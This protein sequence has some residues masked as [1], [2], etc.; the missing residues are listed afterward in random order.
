LG[1]GGDEREMMG[2]LIASQLAS[3]ILRKEPGETRTIVVGV[4]LLKVGLDR[5]AW[6]D[7]LE[8]IAKVV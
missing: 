3:L 5:D 8:L 6:F 4:G 1:A 7:L 2:H